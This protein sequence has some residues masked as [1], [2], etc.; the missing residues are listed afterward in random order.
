MEKRYNIRKLYLNRISELKK[1]ISNNEI[2][3]NSGDNSL[4]PLNEKISS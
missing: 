2:K 4:I 1:F 3:I